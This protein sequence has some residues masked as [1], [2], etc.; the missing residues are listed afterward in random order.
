VLH[1]LHDALTFNGISTHSMFSLV[2]SSLCLGHPCVHTHPLAA[3]P[4]HWRLLT[5]HKA[6][7]E[8]AITCDEYVLF[9]TCCARAMGIDEPGTEEEVRVRSYC[10]HRD[11]DAR[12]VG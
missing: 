1:H 12:P 3:G 6:H 9:F 4:Q 11:A 2:S 7:H 8:K 5:D 10:L